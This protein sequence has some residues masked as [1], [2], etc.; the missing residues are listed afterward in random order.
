M[1]RMTLVLALVTA[2]SLTSLA[3][4][5]AQ[6]PSALDEVRRE[7]QQMRAEY[8]DMLRRMRAD[9]EAKLRAMDDRLKAAEGAATN[10]QQ[11]ATPAVTAAPAASPAAVAA[12]PGGS[13]Y[14]ANPGA[15]NP[16]I[17]VILDGRFASFAR[18]PSTYRIPGF[19]RGEEAGLG[20]RGFSLGETEIAISSNIDHY[21]YGTAIVSIE[22]A[23]TVN[24]EEAYLQTTA[25]PYGFTA[26]A[27]RFFSGIGYMNEQHRHVWDFA[28]AS[29]PYR[30]FLGNQIADDGVQLRWL[31]PTDFFLEF[32]TEAGRGDSFPAGGAADRGMG[33]YSAFVHAGDDLNE[34]SSFRGGLSF[35]QT[36]ANNRTTN[37][38]ADTFTGRSHTAIADLVYKWA[39]NGN[40]VN[41]NLK[42]QGEYFFRREDGLFNGLGYAGHQT[43]WYIQT[44][45][46]FMPQWRVGARY[47]QVR[48]AGLDDTFAG[49]TLD[50]LGA[51]PRRYS[52]MADYS[53]SEFGRFRLQYNRDQ[54]RPSADNQYI[55]QYTVS[56][57]AHGAHAF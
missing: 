44:V 27:G 6:Q 56:L 14:S 19:A 54:S 42:V 26:K 35:L 8:D 39:P 41:T 1:S 48:A 52:L 21:F 16:S 53:T 32:G 50:N 13:A 49:T 3:P 40:P 9:Y 28:D 22:R 25:L 15:F 29:L 57:G 2:A 34:S 10:A 33:L 30:A 38:G 17:G 36:K 20:D 4:A 47:D 37:N 31:A 12:S 7:M 46:Q 51:T 11:S 43:G 55:L 24:V 18:D 5:R 45:Y 23:G